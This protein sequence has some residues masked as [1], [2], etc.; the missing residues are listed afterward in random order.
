MDTPHRTRHRRVRAASAAPSPPRSPP[1][2]AAGRRRPRRR[3][4]RRRRRRAA[5]PGA[6]H[7]RC[8]ATSPT[9]P[10][11]PRSPPPSARGSTCWSTTPA[12]SARARCRRLA[13]LRPDELQ[14]SS[15]STPSPRSR[16]PSRSCRRC[17]TAGG[18]VVDI[19]S[20]AAV[21]AYEGWGGYGASKAA[22]DQLA[23]V[24]AVEHPELR[25]LRRRPRRH[26][27][28][29]APGR[30][31][32]RGHQRPARSG[33]RRPRRCSRWS[34]ATCPAAGTAAADL[35]PGG[36]GPVTTTFALP[37]TRRPPPRRSGGGSRATRCG[38]WPCGPTGRD[39]TAGS[40]TCPTC[41]SP[42][43]SSSSTPR[44]R[45]PARLDARRADGVAV[46]LHVSTPLDDGD[47]VVELRRP[48]QR[49]AR[50]RRR[51]RHGAGRCPA[52]SG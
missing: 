22:L 16:S 50:P 37:P 40:A 28:R 5:P 33:E 27:H 32:R 26:G 35:R 44:P 24:L 42:A 30:L 4:A 13:D 38:C 9:R 34:T 15:R 39:V 8:P 46:P 6:G 45:C 51:A 10:T 11:A 41:S 43:T 36:S 12:T 23:A 17:A 2:L 25:V 47:W 14:R 20:D 21:E 3:P 52:A 18:T 7:R 29:H 1:R 31:P 49:R 19:S 48:G